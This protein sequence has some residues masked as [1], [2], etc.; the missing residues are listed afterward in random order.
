M[1]TQFDILDG[2]YAELQTVLGNETSVS[3]VSD[4]V[5]MLNRHEDGVYPFFGIEVIGEHETMSSGIGSN[6]RVVDHTTDANGDIDTVDKQTRY[7][8]SVSIVAITDNHDYRGAAALLD[9]TQDHFKAFRN[10]KDLSDIHADLKDMT[11]RGRRPFQRTDFS[12]D[13]RLQYDFEYTRIRTVDVESFDSIT[14]ELEDLDSGTQ[15][16]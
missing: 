13:E 2:I 15:Y 9:V 8:M 16:L 1:A 12:I 14:L 3:D 10:E 5:G 4:H 11:P 6:E 7:R